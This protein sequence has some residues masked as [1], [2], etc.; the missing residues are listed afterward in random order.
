MDKYQY[1]L[2]VSAFRDFHVTFGWKMVTLRDGKQECQMS[3]KA[4]KH[5][6]MSYIER[7][8]PEVNNG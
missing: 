7:E 5:F 8:H 1:D 2:L 3:Y 6:I 4:F